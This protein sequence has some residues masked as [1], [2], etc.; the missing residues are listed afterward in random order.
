M[1]IIE[2]NA[3]GINGNSVDDSEITTGKNPS[4]R[5][6]EL[7]LDPE[8]Q[9]FMFLTWVKKWFHS[10]S[11]S[12]FSQTPK[13]TVSRYIITWINFLSFPL[14]TVPIGPAKQ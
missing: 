9:L 6:P 10:L 3:G 13:S 14:G 4:K 11:C 12:M 5:G 1:N 7:K 8:D 2:T